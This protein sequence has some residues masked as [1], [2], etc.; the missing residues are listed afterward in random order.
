MLHVSLRRM[1]AA[2]MALLCACPARR[3]PTESRA[4]LPV[5]L[6]Q[7]ELYSDLRAGTV[8]ASVRPYQP[9]FALWSDGASKRRW[10]RLPDGAQIDTSDMDAWRLPVGT[11]LFKEFS[12]DGKRIETRV[13]RKV[14]RDDDAWAALSYV[15]NEAQDEATAAPEGVIDALGTRHDVPSAR[16]C[17]A[18]HGGRPERVLGFG[19]I[20]LAH[21]AL[22]ESD[23]TLDRLVAEQKLSSPP[24][25]PIRVPGAP[26][27][28]AALGYL[29]ANCGH[30]HDGGRPPDPMYLRPPSYV[31]LSLRVN[32]LRSESSTRADRTAKLLAM[33][34]PA[35][36]HLILR[37]MTT[38]GGA[39]MRRMPPLATEIPDQEGI[40]LIAGWLKRTLPAAGEGE[41]AGKPGRL[42]VP[43]RNRMGGFR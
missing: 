14:G 21:D 25:A 30:C 18:C 22:S 8:A 15:W 20:Q 42:T 37:R 41:G 35:N 5:Q 11:E 7:L 32:D 3:H 23:I 17:M 1:G 19:A 39:F 33:G 9:S 26:E 24:S 28:A 10:I 12:V 38:P 16:T 31:D 2:L 13:L 34:L 29:H 27:D 40:A 43:A 6:S 36:H 4:G